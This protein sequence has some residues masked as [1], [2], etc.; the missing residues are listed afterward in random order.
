MVIIKCP[1]AAES[2]EG[3]GVKGMGVL[4]R[5]PDAKALTSGLASASKHLCIPCKPTYSG[6]GLI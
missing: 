5:Q 6:K 2:A 1:G 3:T 4:D